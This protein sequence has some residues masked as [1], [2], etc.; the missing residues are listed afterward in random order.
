M[1]NPNDKLAKLLRTQPAKLDFLSAL[2]EADRLKLAGDIEQ[3]RQ[4]HSKHIRGS[5]E[6]A[7]NQLPWLLRAPIKKLFGV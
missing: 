4:A 7:L 2:S 3:A 6:E 5:M 1:A